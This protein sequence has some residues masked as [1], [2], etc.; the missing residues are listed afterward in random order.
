MTAVGLTERQRQQL[1]SWVAANM[2]GTRSATWA[3]NQLAPLLG[4]GEPPLPW[5]VLHPLATEVRA[6][7]AR[8]GARAGGARARD[9]ALYPKTCSA[10]GTPFEAISPRASLCNACKRKRYG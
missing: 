4:L 6:A 9:V 1:E 5:E 10:C 2:D 7:C 8:S 3:A